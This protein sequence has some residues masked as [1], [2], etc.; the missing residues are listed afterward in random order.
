MMKK[1]RVLVFPC[2]GMNA[3]ELHEALSSCVNIDV[4]G[5]SSVE[6]H[7]RY[8]FKNYI[9]TI[10]NISEEDFIE[11]L[12]NEI[13]RFNI[14]V[15]FPTHDAVVKY[16]SENKVKIK[17]KII[18]DDPY[19]AKICR[20]K[21]L[22]HN[23][24]ADCNF[25]PIRINSSDH[26]NGELPLFSK[27]DD[28]QGSNG[29]HMINSY[30][31][32]TKEDFNNNLITEY[33]PGKEYTV[34]CFTDR[35][36]NLRYVSIRERKRM[37]AGICVSGITLP[38]NEDIRKI[39]EKINSRLRF[40]GLWYFQLR[41]DKYGAPKLLEISCRCAGTMCLTRSKGINLPLLSVYDAMGYDLSLFE[42]GYSVEMERIFTGLYRIDYDY[43]YVYI[44]FDDTVVCNSNVN[45]NAIKFLYQ[46]R[47]NKIK[48]FLLTR[49]E[50]DINNTLKSYAISESLFE[51]IIHIKDNHP[52]SNYIQ[53]E[54]CIFI[55][56]AY[57][58][59]LEVHNKCKIPVFDADAFEFLIN[60][61]R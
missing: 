39:A 56:N 43:K 46:C 35:H 2:E 26:F 16:L 13:V 60:Y 58:E 12:N 6:R 24:F 40:Q 52:K 33:L 38:L 41:K 30:E 49:H 8:I 3:V 42:N 29:A 25:A 51:N 53:H 45:T 34:D 55:D 32:L 14:D 28:G 54:Q 48:V 10:P 15:I 37:M 36:S 21:I 20:S 5:A 19:T 57:N 9:S 1:I 11:K 47:N 4:L 31:D 22:T 59:R 44:D 7:G 18:S 50:F 23:L 17:T 61:K 27:P